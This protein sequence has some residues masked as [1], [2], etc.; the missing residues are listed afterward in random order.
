MSKPTMFDVLNQQI[1]DIVDYGA[2]V[3]EKVTRRDNHTCVMCNDKCNS[4]NVRAHT[5]GDENTIPS[6]HDT[7][8]VCST[9]LVR[10]INKN[11]SPKRFNKIFLPYLRKVD[12]IKFNKAEEIT[13][14]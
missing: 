12:I 13:D 2:K 5:L 8:T 14:E 4:E 11:G 6:L 7:V 3:F 9:C 1:A 10:V